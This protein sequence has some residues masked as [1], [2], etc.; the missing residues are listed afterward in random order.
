MRGTMVLWNL[1]ARMLRFRGESAGN[2]CVFVYQQLTGVPVGF[3]LKP[4]R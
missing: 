4:I 3:P 1:A 2:P